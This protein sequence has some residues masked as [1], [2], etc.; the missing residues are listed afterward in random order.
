MTAATETGEATTAPAWRC[1]TF[2]GSVVRTDRAFADLQPAPSSACAAMTLRRI[3]GEFP[4]FGELV[5]EFDDPAD[6]A[7]V[8]RACEDENGVQWV[9]RHV[10]RV[11]LHPGGD[12]VEYELAS[13]AQDEDIETYLGGPVLGVA[14]QQRGETLLHAASVPCR[15]GAAAFS[16]PS[17]FGK[18]TLA[19]S[20]TLAGVPL[21]SD[22]ILPVREAGERWLATPFLPKLKLWDESLEGL[23]MR[24]AHDYARAFSW[25]DKKRVDIGRQW[26]S[27]ATGELPLRVLYL[28]RPHL[29]E[30]RRDLIEFRELSTI[31]AA[32]AVQ[33]AMYMPELLRGARARHALEAGARLASTV[34]VRLVSYYRSF[35]GLEALRTRLLA[36][37]DSIA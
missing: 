21:L 23:G 18:S 28:L 36:D 2:G 17:G 8:L 12:L 9:I 34:P 7:S 10:G 27:M 16:A 25:L 1:F 3:E 15:G 32:L 5:R 13:D 35:D 31:E 30:A 37:A 6:G 19:A 29:N 22:D 26:G 24:D 11:W 4:P 33:G 14:A 20:F